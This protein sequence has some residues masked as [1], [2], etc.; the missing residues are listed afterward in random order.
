LKRLD[1]VIAVKSY[2]VIIILKLINHNNLTVT[3]N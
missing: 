2:I 3:D 1:I